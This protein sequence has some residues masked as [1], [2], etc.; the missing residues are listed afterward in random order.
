MPR[1]RIV[2]LYLY[3]PI[4]LHGV[5]LYYK[6]GDSFTLPLLRKCLELFLLLLEVAF[7]DSTSFFCNTTDMSDGW[8]VL[9]DFNLFRCRP[10]GMNVGQLQQ[11]T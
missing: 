5:V 9:Y 8:F 3:S 11:E 10:C 4:R 1:L 2:E 7:G 6:H